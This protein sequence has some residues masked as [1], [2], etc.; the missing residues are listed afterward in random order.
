MTPRRSTC[1]GCCSTPTWHR[2][3]PRDPAGGRGT[4]SARRRIGPGSVMSAARVAVRSRRADRHQPGRHRLGVGDPDPGRL[5]LRRPRLLVRGAVRPVWREPR[6][7]SRNVPLLAGV[8]AAH[9]AGDAASLARV[10]GGVLGAQSRRTDLDDRT[11]P[12]RGPPVRSTLAGARRDHDGKHPPA[13]CRGDRA[14]VPALGDMGVPAPDQGDARRRRPVVRRSARLAIAGHRRRRDAGDR[15]NLV[16]PRA[17]GVARLV[18]APCPIIRRPGAR[19]DRR[20][21]RP[22]LAA[23]RH[24]GRGRG[25]RRMVWLAVDR[26]DRRVRRPSRHVVIRP[27][28]PR[29]DPADR[30]WHDVVARVRPPPRA[31]RGHSRLRRRPSR[32]SSGREPRSRRG[33]P[34]TTRRPL[35]DPW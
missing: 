31:G 8:R 13:D 17:R 11:D 15:G 14:R 29:R 30:A 20:G 3:R 33:R 19:G 6:G 12:G 27:L 4:D 9:L 22:A 26:A 35:Q 1:S 24:R 10:R 34:R 32:R 28:D 18:R 5:L 7:P 2:L 25:C 23:N 21:A 16:H